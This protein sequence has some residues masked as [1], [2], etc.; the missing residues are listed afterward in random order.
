MTLTRRFFLKSTGIALAGFAAV[1]S[2]LKRTA[3]GM[4]VNE[5]RSAAQRKILVG[6]F[7][8]G[9]ADGLNGVVPFGERAYYDARPTLAIPEP[10]SGDENAALDL[11]GF[12]GLHPRLS[13]FKPIYDA[14][15]LAIVHAAGSP[16]NTRS[17]FDAQDYMESATPGVKS[18][19]DGWLN[20]YLQSIPSRGTGVSSPFRAVSMTPNLPR[21]LQ[22]AA[23]A[24]AINNLNDFALRAGPSS[25]QMQRGFE[26]LYEQ[27]ARDFLHGTGRETFEAVDLLKKAN[28]AQ[29]RPENGATYP[30]GSFGNAMRQIAQLIKSDVGL[31]VAF[32]EIGGWDTH[33]NEGSS[34]GQLAN[35]LDEFARGIAA[36][37][38]DLG[39][40]MENVVIL[41]MSEFGRMVRENGS[42]GTDHG[43]ANCLF[44]LGGPVKGGKVYGKWPGLGLDQL[45]ENR[46]LAV[47]TDFRDVFSE[48]VA[49][50]LGATNLNAIFPGYTVRPSNF[51][52]LIG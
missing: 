38:A 51:R 9:A 15:H 40:R 18:T 12:F 11:D 29:H 49:K 50:H 8:R 13:P 7:Q 27:G 44:L 41:T 4:S 46:D 17:H 28:P 33:A 45:Y 30:N 14:G 19:A 47:T 3:F 26:S 5:G 37:Y 23:P 20:R 24:L 21:T 48:V 6:I 42:R 1:P 35:R 16:D 52:G 43:H 32:A 25:N 36:F 10:K 34:T 2:F 39:G 22:G 31:E